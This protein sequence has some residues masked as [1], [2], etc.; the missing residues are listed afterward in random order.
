MYH[1]NPNVLTI[2]SR[3]GV[4]LM[5]LVLVFLT[6]CDSSPMEEAQPSVEPPTV[7]PAPQ[8]SPVDTSEPAPGIEMSSISVALSGGGQGL[9]FFAQADQ[10]VFYR[11]VTIQPPPP[12]EEVTYNLGNTFI[13]KEQSIGLQ[14]DNAA[15]RKVGG[16]WTFV[17]EV[18]TGTGASAENHTMSQDYSV[19]GKNMQDA[20]VASGLTATVAR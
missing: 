14:A 15:Y 1:T 5:A 13:I 18:T 16:T 6:G 7:E 11:K 9:Q 2:S 17:F 20:D 10:D 8:P 19:A 4:L 12:F 3:L